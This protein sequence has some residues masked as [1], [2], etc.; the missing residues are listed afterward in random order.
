VSSDRVDT[1]FDVRLTDVFPDGKSILINNGAIRMCFKNGFTKS[2]ESFMAKG[3]IYDCNIRLH[4]IYYTFLKGHQIRLDITSANYPLYNRNMNTGSIM[5]PGNSLDSLFGSLTAKNTI[6]TNSSFSSLIRLPQ[7]N[8]AA[9]VKISTLTPINIYPNP[10]KD[11]L[12]IKL[13]KPNSEG[14]NLVIFN[15]FGQILIKESVSE[16]ATINVS[17]LS[18]GIYYLKATFKDQVFQQKLVIE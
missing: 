15:H 14:I 8:N 5:Y 7:I 13:N 18:S 1:D 3:E 4:Y 11:V 9:S 6:Y 2:A 16:S 10:A 17:N 12:H